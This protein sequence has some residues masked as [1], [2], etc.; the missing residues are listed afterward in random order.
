M[1]RDNEQTVVWDTVKL[2]A[3]LTRTIRYA[4]VLPGYTKEGIDSLKVR[5]RTKDRTE[6]EVKSV[7]LDK[8]E[9]AIILTIGEC[10]ADD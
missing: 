6:Y 5:F 7:A 9:Q 2:I 10:N 3:L 1:G 4:M 8:R